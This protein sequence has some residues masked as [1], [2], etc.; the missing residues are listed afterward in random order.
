MAA[1]IRPWLEDLVATEISTLLAWHRQSNQPGIK[2]DPEVTRFSYDGSNFRSELSSPPLDS[3]CKV[4]LVK[5]CSVP[6]SMTTKLR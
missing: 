1:D 3:D 4:Q 6:S 2:P 5:V